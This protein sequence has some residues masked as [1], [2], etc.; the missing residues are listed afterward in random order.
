M[1]EA[2][3]W[4]TR[5]PVIPAGP[6]EIEIRPFYEAADSG[7]VSCRPSR[8]TPHRATAIREKLGVA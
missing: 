8:R 7:P 6:G 3:A 1:D 2:M 4:A 5:S